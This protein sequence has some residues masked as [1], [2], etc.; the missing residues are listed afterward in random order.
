MRE[1]QANRYPASRFRRSE[2]VDAKR[3][4]E[5]TS[6]SGVNLAKAVIKLI[7]YLEDV[8]CRPR[9]RPLCLSLARF[10]FNG[11]NYQGLSNPPALSFSPPPPPFSRPFPSPRL[12]SLAR[13]APVSPSFFR[14]FIRFLLIE[15]VALQSSDLDRRAIEF[16]HYRLPAQPDETFAGRGGRPACPPAGGTVSVKEAKHFG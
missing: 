14:L 5:A 6:R 15:Q 7:S 13:R 11:L 8:P 2:R 4:G 1:F 9:K 10:L 16:P 3:C 12:R